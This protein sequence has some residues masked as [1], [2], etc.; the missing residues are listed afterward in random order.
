MDTMAA[1]RETFFQEC[2]EQ[3]GELEVGLIAMDE[4]DAD[5]ETVNA[6]FRAVHSI[7]GGAGA[8]KLDRLVRFAHT[9]ETASISSA[10]SSS[11]PRAAVMKTHAALGRR[12][13]GSGRRRR[14]VDQPV[15]E[16]PHRVADR[17]AE[18]PGRR[19]ASADRWPTPS[20]GEADARSIFNPLCSLSTIEPDGRRTGGAIATPST[21]TPRPDLYRK[22][23]ETVRLLRELSAG[24]NPT[25]TATRG[26]CRRLDKLD[27][28]G[29][30]LIWRI[31]LTTTEDQPAIEEVFD[32]VVDDCELEI[33]SSRPRLRRVE[34]TR[35]RRR[36][37]STPPA[38]AERVGFAVAVDS[39]AEPTRARPQDAAPRI[40]AAA[41]QEAE[42]PR[43]RARQGRARR[44]RPSA[45]ISSASTV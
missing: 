43:S 16:A 18:G 23:N 26:A 1:I 28:E 3:L 15:D 21:F 29:A 12:A 14:A 32:F 17:R 4:G 5:S 38:A 36:A 39:R 35:P 37:G 22:G 19:R 30:Y 9:F 11:R 42:K 2:E 33:V 45:S 8:F 34:A 27:P 13:R 31:E 6:V 20:G 40:D 7:K 25:L 41:A 24:R 44:R 10:A